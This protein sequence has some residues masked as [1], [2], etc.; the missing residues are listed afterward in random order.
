MK[1]PWFVQEE[2][3]VALVTVTAGALWCVRR[4]DVGS[5]VGRPL[6]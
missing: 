4:K 3:E 5:F 6:G 2:Q 1:R